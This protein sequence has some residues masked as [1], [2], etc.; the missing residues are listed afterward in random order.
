[1]AGSVNDALDQPV[2]ECLEIL[3]NRH[4]VKTLQQ[5]RSSKLSDLNPN[6][7]MVTLALENLAVQGQA[8]KARRAAK[9]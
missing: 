3:E 6:D 8:A 5:V 4:Y 7:P 1:M 9:L 2:N